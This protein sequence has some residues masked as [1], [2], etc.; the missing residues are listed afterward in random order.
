MASKDFYSLWQ[1]LVWCCHQAQC[2]W[3]KNKNKKW[4]GVNQ[5]EIADVQLPENFILWCTNP[6][7]Q[8]GGEEAHL[9]ASTSVLQD[10]NVAHYS[11]W[12]RSFET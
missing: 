10:R 1:I 5:S 6:G 4:V 7:V 12:K 2:I 3:N 11:S 9:T 8:Y